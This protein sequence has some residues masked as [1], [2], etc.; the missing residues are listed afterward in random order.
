MHDKNQSPPKSDSPL[1]VWRESAQYWTKH[2]GTIHKMFAPLTRALI[3]HAGIREG[4]SVLDVAAGAGEPSLTIAE[5]VGPRGSVTCTD[6]VL[7]MVET[8]RS[9]ANRRGLKNI[10]F[11]QCMA[12]S[13]PF[14]A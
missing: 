9:E 11:R 4:Q 6:A 2:S 7:E 5:T 1:D 13:L 8:A 14:P 12:D 10:E 3:E